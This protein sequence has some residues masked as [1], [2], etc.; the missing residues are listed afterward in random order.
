[1][2]TTT[3]TDSA[4]M[5][6]VSKAELEELRKIK[7]QLPTVIEQAKSEE[8]KDALVRLHQRDKENPEISRERSKKYYQLHKEEVKARRLEKRNAAASS[9]N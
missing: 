4:E 6:L 7:E 5:V 3:P 2:S 8:R 9:K 1:M